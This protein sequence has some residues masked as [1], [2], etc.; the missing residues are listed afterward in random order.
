MLMI[1]S[2][3]DL[4]RERAGGKYGENSNMSESES[5]RVKKYRLTL[6]VVLLWH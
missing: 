5:T 2:E 1:F 4:E 6:I 3:E